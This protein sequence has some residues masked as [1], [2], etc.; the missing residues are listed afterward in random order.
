MMT[1]IWHLSVSKVKGYLLS[2]CMAQS[3]SRQYYHCLL[4]FSELETGECLSQIPIPVSKYLSKSS[5]HDAFSLSNDGTRV[6]TVGD[7]EAYLI[8]LT[9]LKTKKEAKTVAVFNKD[10]RIPLMQISKNGRY[11]CAS[12]PGAEGITY[13]HVCGTEHD[14]IAE[15]LLP[16][17][18]FEIIE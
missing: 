7:A 1:Q 12:L 18:N 14:S 9:S 15:E 5:V 11:V 13:F 16:A 17:K 3:V 2:S 4:V 8:D 6:L 10:H